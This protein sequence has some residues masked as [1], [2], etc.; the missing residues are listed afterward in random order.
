MADTT[1]GHREYVAERKANIIRLTEDLR[2][3]DSKLTEFVGNPNQ[4]ATKYGLKLTEE[5]ASALAAIAGNQE[6]DDEAL[7]AV[8]GGSLSTNNGCINNNC[9]V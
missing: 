6:L 2:T 4:V 7:S 3:S 9:A 8:A 1:D 5:E